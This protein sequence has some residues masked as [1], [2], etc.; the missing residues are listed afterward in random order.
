MVSRLLPVCSL[1]GRAQ[2]MTQ[3][4]AACDE[5]KGDEIESPVSKVDGPPGTHEG[6]WLM[7]Y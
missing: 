5:D 6:G 2:S 7:L 1:G 3:A 4:H